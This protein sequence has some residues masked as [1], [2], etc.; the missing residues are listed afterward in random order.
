MRKLGILALA[1]TMLAAPPARAEAATIEAPPSLGVAGMTQLERLPVL[2]GR[3]QA[4]GASSHA[5]DGGN[6]DSKPYLERDGAGRYVLMEAEGP[7]AVTRVWMTGQ[8]TRGTGDTTPY[9]NIAFFFDG[10]SVPRID[11]PV[12]DFF[13]GDQAAFPA[14]LCADYHV[15]SGGNY[16]D[17]RIPFAKSMR[18]TTT[19][20]PGYYG[21]GY[22]TYSADAVVRSFEPKDPRTLTDLTDA[23]RLWARA[24]GDPRILPPGTVHSG[25][26]S[27]PAG[28]RAALL[29][30]SR[31]GT[32]RAVRIAL[33]RH[34]DATLRSVR[35]RARWDGQA[36]PAVDAPLADLFAT[37]AGE[38]SPATGLL[39]GYSPARHEGYLYFPMPFTASADVELVNPTRQPVKATWT[40]EEAPV[41]YRSAGLFHATFR[42]EPHTTVG[43]DF[44]LLDASGA[45]KVVGVSYTQTGQSVADFTTFMEGDERVYVDGSRSP[46]L[47]GTGTEDFFSGGYYYTSLFALPDHGATTKEQVTPVGAQ[48]SQYRLMLSDPWEFRDGI[49][50]GIEHAAGNGQVTA[51][52]SVVFWYAGQDDDRRL[53]Q[54]AAID[55]PSAGYSGAGT[56]V[57]LTAFFEGDHDGNL[58][59]PLDWLVPGSVPPPPGTDPMGE[60]MTEIGRTHRVGATIRFT[61]TLD[62]ANH[63]VILRRLLDQGTF[64]QRAEVL[65]DGEPAGIWFTPGANPSKRW[66]ESDFALP[67]S[68]TRGKCRVLIELH[69]LPPIDPPSGVPTGWTDFRY[70]AL[71]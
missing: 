46:A 36:V 29:H 35:L 12:A 42:D 50:A 26:T 10:E 51:N 66:A 58:S 27:I 57:T 3:A 59:P 8:S 30:I 64:G 68:L 55:V 41:T 67:A 61:M 34:D 63:G 25:Q 32:I 71:S 33:D 60:S 1:L 14:P 62:P 28:G 45:G 56:D 70:V 39:V 44:T 5:R 47:Y 38:R 6:S 20:A 69:V 18:I 19:D 49:H 9:G 13:R 48:T 40:V 53:R 4:L 15:S 65:V 31:A 2:D 21:I 17:L 7:G 52:R 24:G 43:R 23:A 54:T 22:E 11:V 37:G 16:C